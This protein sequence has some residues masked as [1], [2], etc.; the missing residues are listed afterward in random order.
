M[1]WSQRLCDCLCFHLFHTHTN[2]EAH[3]RNLVPLNLILDSWLRIKMSLHFT[4][5]LCLQLWFHTLDESSEFSSLFFSEV[6]LIK[7]VLVR[8]DVDLWWMQTF[9]VEMLYFCAVEPWLLQFFPLYSFF[10]PFF[11]CARY[12]LSWKMTL[13]WFTRMDNPYFF[14]LGPT[15]S[16]PSH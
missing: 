4:E 10:C 14:F 16:E 11:V 9:Y 13:C 7:T 3:M 12:V 6:F 8:C 15:N 1:A 2:T 5:H